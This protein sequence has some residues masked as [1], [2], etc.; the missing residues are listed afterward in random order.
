MSQHTTPEVMV[1]Y[2]T[3]RFKCIRERPEP[4]YNISEKTDNIQNNL[5]SARKYIKG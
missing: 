4:T 3:T 1:G 2:N 5:K